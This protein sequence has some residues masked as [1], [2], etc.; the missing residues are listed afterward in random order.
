MEYVY[1]YTDVDNDKVIY[2]GRTTDL[3]GRFLQHAKEPWTKENNFRC[4]YIEVNNRTES[5]ALEGHFIELYGTSKDRGGRNT[6]KAGWGLMSFAPEVEW[7]TMDENTAQ[8]TRLISELASLE[9]R[10]KAGK[11]ELA[12]IENEIREAKRRL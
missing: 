8:R 11:I 4:E 9:E 5:E 1:K 12:C 6:K 3:S 7:L 10:I 2:V